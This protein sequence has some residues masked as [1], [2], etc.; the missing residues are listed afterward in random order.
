MLYARRTAN[1][2]NVK[3]YI[4]LLND[5]LL[6]ENHHD[7]DQLFSTLY[8]D[9]IGIINGTKSFYEVERESLPIVAYL[10]KNHKD[11]FQKINAEKIEKDNLN[12]L[13]QYLEEAA[14]T[15]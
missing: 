12:E 6:K 2:G 8:K 4:F 14:N 1:Q 3:M 7:I 13:K 11:H 5:F 15:I 10:A 9:T